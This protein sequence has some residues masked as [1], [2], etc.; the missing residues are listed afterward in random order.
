MAESEYQRTD[1]FN[2]MET[3]ETRNMGFLKN[4]RRNALDHES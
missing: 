1:A 4:L 2:R 3:S